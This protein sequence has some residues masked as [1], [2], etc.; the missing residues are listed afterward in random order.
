MSENVSFEGLQAKN[1]TVRFDGLVAL[2]NVS[3]N[4]RTGNITGIVGPNGA[5][6]SSFLNAIMG[7]VPLAG[8]TISINDIIISNTAPWKRIRLGLGRAFQHVELFGSLTVEENVLLGRHHMMRYGVLSAGLWL[9][10][11]RVAELSHRK[12]VDY[13]P[14][15]LRA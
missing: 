10:R 6:K 11:A 9:R 3:L 13:S 4:A 5:G 15:I 8:G 14:R 2:D 12:E 7:L 1:V